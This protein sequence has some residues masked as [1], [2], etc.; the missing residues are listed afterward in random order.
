MRWLYSTDARDIGILYLYLSAFSG[1]LGTSMS[2]G[3]RL[4]LM[5]INQSSV[6]N[7]P[8]QAYNNM[9]TI[10][11][12][13]MIFFL[14][15]PAMFGGFGKIYNKNGLHKIYNYFDTK[16]QYSSN[17]FLSDN[18]LTSSYLAG[19]IEGDGTI[20]VSE[21]KKYNVRIIIV[22]NKNDLKLAEFLK[23][24]YNCGT[25]NNK[26]N[27]GYVLW[28][29][30]DMNGVIKILKLING[31]MRTPKID[32][33]HKAINYFK[34]KNLIDSNYKLL[35]IDNTSIDSNAWLSGFTDADGNF[36]INISKRKNNNYRVS[37]YYRL[38]IKQNYLKENPHSGR[39]TDINNFGEIS[40]FNIMSKISLF[41]DVNLYSRTRKTNF[42][43]SNTFMVMAH[44][45]KNLINIINY[46]S[47]YPLFSSK[48]LNYK[49]W[50][51]VYNL[52]INNKL[53]KDYLNEVLIIKNNFNSKRTQF[54]WDHLNNFYK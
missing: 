7:L 4:Q 28:Q 24:Y 17:N 34:D 38:E 3:I 37:I 47:K 5:D 14:V 43:L 53:T 11:A 9:I 40:F 36:S 22:F 51:K 19:L 44:S 54:N 2:M 25:I 20:V 35:D 32:T 50:L 18:K 8:N 49:D 26:N 30:Q 16:Y 12:I 13:L 33:L 52:K 6:L 21:K 29:I 46:F 31:Y 41:L 1:I 27:L 48:Y 15:M 10:H 23:N 45:E 39:V 42:G